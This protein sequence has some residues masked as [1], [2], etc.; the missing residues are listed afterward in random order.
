[1]SILITIIGILLAG[2]IALVTVFYI[3]GRKIHKK[4]KTTHQRENYRTYPIGIP[5]RTD[6]AGR[7]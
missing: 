4:P 5:F 2:Y 3:D 6:D 1:M 7:P